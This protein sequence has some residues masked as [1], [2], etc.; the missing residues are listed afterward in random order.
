MARQA[1]PGRNA[2]LSRRERPGIGPGTVKTGSRLRRE[3][4]G[5]RVAV[6]LPPDMAMELRVRCVR[7]RRSVSDAVTEAVGSWLQATAAS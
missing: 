6:Y 4:T 3:A 1:S 5:D 2:Q 7:E